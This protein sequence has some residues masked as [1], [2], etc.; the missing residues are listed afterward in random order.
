MKLKLSPPWVEFASEVKA[1]FSGDKEVT[2]IYD[3]EEKVISLYVDNAQKAEALTELLPETKEF[4]GVTVKVTVVP[5]NGMTGAPAQDVW[6]AAF[7]GN[8]NFSSVK[9]V[10]CPLGNFTY[11]VWRPNAVQFFNDNLG[12]VNGNQTMLVQDVAKDI[13]DPE[14]GVYHCSAQLLGAP[15]GEWP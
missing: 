15:L 7:A 5:A 3:D 13:F 12:D 8:P 2:V 10:Q 9:F 14:L 1:L 4:G 11:V 6:K